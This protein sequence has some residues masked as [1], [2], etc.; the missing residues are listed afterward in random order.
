MWLAT[1]RPEAT[2]GSGLLRAGDVRDDLP[3]PETQLRSRQSADARM[4]DG[5]GGRGPLG[6]RGPRDARRGPRDRGFPDPQRPTATPSE[7]KRR[8][9]SIIHPFDFREALSTS[10][11]GLPGRGR[12]GDERA[13]R[14]T[15][16]EHLTFRESHFYPISKGLDS[17]RHGY[18]S[19]T[20]LG[21]VSSKRSGACPHVCLTL[22]SLR[23]PTPPIS[24]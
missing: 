7:A 12:P 16:H 6:G 11:S 24:A 18:K 13:K 17:P 15:S 21:P 5:R 22:G 2:V 8:V 3:A 23:T 20:F 19:T 4:D 10:A 9:T 14:F 1:P